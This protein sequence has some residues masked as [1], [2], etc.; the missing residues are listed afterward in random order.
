MAQ[1]FSRKFGSEC[2]ETFSPMI[3]FLSVRTIFSFAAWH[4]LR[5]M[6]LTTDAV[7]KWKSSRGGV[8][9]TARGF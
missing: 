5:Q 9:E 3:S 4:G 2:D 8:Y 1:G 6:D 7:L